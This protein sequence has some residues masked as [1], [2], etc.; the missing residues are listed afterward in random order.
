M[1]CSSCINCLL[2]LHQ[3]S[4]GPP[5]DPVHAASRSKVPLHLQGM[6]LVKQMALTDTQASASRV[7]LLTIGQQAIMD[8]YLC[9][10]HLTTGKLYG[11]CHA[12]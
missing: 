1:L 2:A 7:S 10:L 11:W 4:T 8:A 6:L 12:W 3:R 9:L 5:T